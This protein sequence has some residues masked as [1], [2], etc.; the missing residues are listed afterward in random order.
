MGSIAA[1][2]VLAKAVSAAFSLV[3]FAYNFL[4]DHFKAVGY[5]VYAV[6][7]LATLL[8]ATDGAVDRTL[9][10]LVILASL[11]VGYR[12]AHRFALPA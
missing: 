12:I 9:V 11:I 6:I 8:A 3:L 10:V 1:L 2:V 5:G 7:I 4:A